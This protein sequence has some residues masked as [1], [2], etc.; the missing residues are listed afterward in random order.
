M[1]SF[2]TV[3]LLTSRARSRYNLT[4][5]VFFRIFHKKSDK[6]RKNFSKI[7]V[8]DAIRI[9]EARARAAPCVRVCSRET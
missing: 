8:I 7:A 4:R 9:S 2:K 6:A 5:E 3:K 1:R